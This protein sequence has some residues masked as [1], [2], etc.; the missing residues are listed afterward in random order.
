MDML[1][2]HEIKENKSYISNEQRKIYNEFEND[3]YFGKFIKYMNR[4]LEHKA[5]D[6]HRKQKK[7]NLREIELEE[8]IDISTED[9]YE[10]LT[11]NS[12]EILNQKETFLL[13]LHYIKKM[14]YTEISKITNE[15]VS[16]LK[17]RRNR[18]IVK[19]KDKLEGKSYERRF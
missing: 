3:V 4:A 17:Q 8:I 7:L 6:Y 1:E 10:F 5:I 18:A 11:N 19:L 12:F 14:S 2:K 16:T 13:E 9:N 15:K